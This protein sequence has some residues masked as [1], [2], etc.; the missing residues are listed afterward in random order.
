MMEVSIDISELE[1]KLPMMS[2]K[3][4]AFMRVELKHQ[5]VEIQ[6][7]AMKNHRH[8]TRRKTRNKTRTGSLNSSIQRQIDPS[9][10][11]GSVYLETGIADYGVYVHEGHGA[12]GKS[13]KN[14]F[15]YVWE[16]DQFIYKALEAREPV[17]R[18]DF[19]VTVDN[20]L[21]AAGVA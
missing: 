18:A 9:E 3:I 4:E 14:G 13:V 16:P 17:I 21:V 6:K 19:E 10:M 5:L 11:S 2:E 7:Y 1:S 12:P 20:A 8:K 15:P